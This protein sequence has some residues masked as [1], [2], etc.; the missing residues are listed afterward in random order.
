MC[1]GGGIWL[2]LLEMQNLRGGTSLGWD[3]QAAT[4]NFLG[5]EIGHSGQR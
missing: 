1:G 3:W 4:C 2:G 5:P